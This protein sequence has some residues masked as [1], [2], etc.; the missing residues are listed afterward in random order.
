VQL[1]PVVTKLQRIMEPTLPQVRIARDT[2][3]QS[4]KGF[5]F[6]TFKDKA[7]AAKAVADFTELE[8]KVRLRLSG[9]FQ[10]RPLSQETHHEWLAFLPVKLLA[11]SE[12]PP[13]SS[14]FMLAGKKGGPNCPS[15]SDRV[16]RIGPADCASSIVF[17]QFDPG[18]EGQVYPSR[19]YLCGRLILVQGQGACTW[20]RA[21]DKR[22]CCGS[23]IVHR[24]QGRLVCGELNLLSVST[25]S[26]LYPLTAGEICEG[27]QLAVKAPPLCGGHP[28]GPVKGGAPE[29]PG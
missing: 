15:S 13:R 7:A 26:L 28:E 3:D 14:F 12:L 19:R 29:T 5:A 21:Q 4:P 24:S 10:I 9:S 2:L 17:C 1:L 22:H 20:P 18:V 25:D 23:L 27:K 16:V 8:I 6:V 11:L